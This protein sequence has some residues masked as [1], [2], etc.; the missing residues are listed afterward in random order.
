MNEKSPNIVNIT[1]GQTDADLAQE[2][3]DEMAPHL[4]ALCKCMDKAR[5][6]GMQAGFSLVPD[7]FGR[8]NPPFVIITKAL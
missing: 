7:A 8:H 3:R 4:A 1:V 2:I 5:S 6:H